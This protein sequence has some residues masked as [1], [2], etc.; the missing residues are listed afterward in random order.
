METVQ[1]KLSLDRRDLPA[2]LLE[3]TEFKKEA[4]ASSDLSTDWKTYHP[5][6]NKQPK[7]D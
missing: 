6:I 5:L 4:I 3:D 2:K 1:F 7:A